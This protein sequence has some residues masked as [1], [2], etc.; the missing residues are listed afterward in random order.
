MTMT[1]KLAAGL[2]LFVMLG[3]CSGGGGLLSGPSSTSMATT[4]VLDG[5]LD[6]AAPHGFCADDGSSTSASGTAFV[7]FGSC[8]AIDGTGPAPRSPAILTAAVSDGAGAVTSDDVSRLV[9]YLRTEPG[10]AGLA[11]SGSAGGVEIESLE[12]TGDLVL[13]RA[14]DGA[15]DMDPAF[16]RAIFPQSGALVTLTVSSLADAPIPAATG[17]ALAADFVAAI[18]SANAPAGTGTGSAVALSEP[19]ADPASAKTLSVQDVGT[20]PG[21]VR[22][23]FERLL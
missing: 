8:Q 18:Q 7:L 15:P 5:K 2:A 6:L 3:A 1:R 10:R 13:L 22:A 14:R 9:A 12:R 23:F 19:A 4:P 11:R 20:K 16:W 21:G 17:K